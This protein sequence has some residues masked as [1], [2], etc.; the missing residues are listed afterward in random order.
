MHKTL[1]PNVFVK[2]L[3]ILIFNIHLQRFKNELQNES[4]NINH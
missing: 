4:L 1:C 3:K 2:L